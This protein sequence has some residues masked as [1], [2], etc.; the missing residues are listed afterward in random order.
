MN[1]NFEDKVDGM[2]SYINVYYEDGNVL[3]RNNNG[4]ENKVYSINIKDRDGYSSKDENNKEFF[5]RKRLL[6]F[7]FFVIDS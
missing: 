4:V 3:N 7:E 6:L 5:R 2:V 1:E